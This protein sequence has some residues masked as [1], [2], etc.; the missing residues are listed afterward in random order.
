MCSFFGKCII[1]V[2]INGD[3]SRFICSILFNLNGKNIHA[4]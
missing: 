4:F 3:L 1:L 2:K